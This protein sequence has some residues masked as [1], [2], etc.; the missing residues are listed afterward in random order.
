MDQYGDILG[1][2]RSNM[3]SSEYTVY[4]SRIHRSVEQGQGGNNVR[5][6][7]GAVIY[8]KLQNNCSTIPPRKMQV[9]INPVETNVETPPTYT[10][11]TQ[12]EEMLK[13][14]KYKF[15]TASR[16]FSILES[17]TPQWDEKL[18][19]FVL[20]FGGRVTMDSEKN[21]QLVQSS[22]NKD[23]NKEQVVLLQFG[24]VAKD[25]FTMDFQWPLSPFLAFALSLSSC[26]SKVGHD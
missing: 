1:K 25:E 5:A 7:L 8:Q 10:P 26:D 11:K 2:L 18:E 19:S 21:F 23:A 4:D 22:N 14:L 6:E 9:C 17:K 24:R 20:N 13:L 12:P 15:D 3:F 16:N